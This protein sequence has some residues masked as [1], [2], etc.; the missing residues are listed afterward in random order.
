MIAESQIDSSEPGSEEPAVHS[1]ARRAELVLTRGRSTRHLAAEIART[2]GL[3][4]R[5][6]GP[7]PRR[8]PAEIELINALYADET[9]RH[10]LVRHG[11][12][13]R[14]PGGPIWQRFPVPLQLSS[15]LAEELYVG[16]GLAARHIELLTGQPSQTVLTL[17][18]A[19][20]IARMPV[21]GTAPF[22]R[23]WRAGIQRTGRPPGCDGAP[24]AAGP[25]GHLP[26]APA[27]DQS[28]LC[29]LRSSCAVR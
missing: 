6:G 10:A 14:P 9:V 7:R 22:M 12:P 23:R 20:G 11:I 27:C 16:C 26:G 21:G 8:G 19:H 29:A 17:L 28:D 25:A 18:K 3:P 1:R 15:Q 5:M 13:S 24:G 2:S 4:V